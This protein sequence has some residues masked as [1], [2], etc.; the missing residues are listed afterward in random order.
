MLKLK[1]TFVTVKYKIVGKI[2]LILGFVLVV[3]NALDYLLQ[4][5]VVNNSVF[6]VG[7]SL[8]AIGLYLVKI[9]K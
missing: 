9:P 6:T 2:L 3:V 4:W 8:C 1:P 7:M 5:N